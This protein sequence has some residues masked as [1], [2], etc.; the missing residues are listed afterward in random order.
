MTTTPNPTAVPLARGR[1]SDPHTGVR[2]YFASDS[3][4]AIQ[5]VL[6]LIWLLDGGLQLQSYMYSHAFPQMLAGMEAGQPHWLSSSIGWGARLAAGNLGFWNSLFA[7]TQIAIGLGLLYRPTVRLALAGSF[8]WVFIVWWFGEA[9]GMLFMNMANPLTGA[10]GAVLL[11]ALIGAI[12]W[13]NDRP[14]GLLGRRGTKIAWA[15]LWIVAA[16]LWLLAPNSSANATSNLIANAPS[17]THW[18]TTLLGDGAKLTAG[19][20]FLIAIVLAAASLAIAIAVAT[21][22]QAPTFLWLAIYLNTAYWIFGQGFGGIFTGGGTDPN[23]GPLFILLAAAL[24]TL[25]PSE[26]RRTAP[27]PEHRAFA[28]DTP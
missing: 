25:Q 18:L 24:Y 9:F 7:V 13:P 23:A 8:V 2:T 17:G 14:G 28:V 1:R 4:R 6:G 20:G 5:T 11:Y 22:W 26:S 12:V 15:T 3:R 16:W 21:D 10:P 19:N 27:A